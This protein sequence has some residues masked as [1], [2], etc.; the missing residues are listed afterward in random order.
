MH[1][2]RLLGTL[3]ALG[4]IASAA[5][6]GQRTSLAPRQASPYWLGQVQH[7]GLA[8]FNSNPQSYQVF[9]NVKDFGAKGDGV[10][11]DSDAINAAIQAGNRCMKGCDSSTTQPGLIYFPS[12]TYL[13]TK[14]IIAVY[15]S[16]L[17]GDAATLPVIKAAGSFS[18]IAVFDSD[19]Y[20][21]DG[22][23]W[24]TNQ[25]N[26]FRAI[27]NFV[28]D[29]TATQS[30]T[31][32]HWQ[33]A[34]ASSLINIRFEMGNTDSQGI[35][36]DNGSGGFMSDLVFRGGKLGAFL[37]NQ[38]FTTRNF[39]FEGVKTAMVLNWNWG[40][41]FKSLDIKNCG[42]GIDMTAGGAEAQT[43]GSVL[44]LDSKI[45]N[46]PIGI[47]TVHSS[48]S[49][50]ITG[51]TLVIDNLSTNNVPVI[52]ANNDGGAILAGSGGATKVESWGQGRVYSPNG[53]SRVQA[54]LTP[55]PQKPAALLDG[56]G[57]IFERSRPQYTDV[58]AAQIV[59]ARSNGAKGD[60]M[61]DDTA[62]LQAL[63]NNNVGKVIFLDHGVYKLTSTLYIPPNTKIV[64][65]CWATLISEGPFFADSKNPKVVIQVGKP[66]EVGL[67]E[68]SDL[69]LETAGPAGGAIVLQWNMADAP[70]TKGTNGMWDVHI[71]I[72]GSAGT[73]LQSDQCKKNPSADGTQINHNCESAFMLMHIGK[74]GSVY[75]ENNWIWTSDHELDRNDF[76][77]ITIFSG[78]GLWI[79][80]QEGPVWGY[81]T[82]SE[83]NVMYQYQLTNTKN[84]FLGM[85][86]TETPYY[87]S[88]PTVYLPYD[89]NPAFEDP[90]YDCPDKSQGSTCAKSIGLRV[91]DSKDILVYGAGLYS[92][93][94]NYTQ[95]CLKTQTCQDDM[96]SVEGNTQNFFM[97]N[98]NTVGV[99]NM[100]KVNERKLVPQAENQNGFASTI[101]LFAQP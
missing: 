1:L 5:P 53:G 101:A 78:R 57:Y 52:V 98:L 73:K 86:Q 43:V 39:V 30:G 55:R 62:A 32:I 90:V 22:S 19:P 27:R 38:Q 83:H 35:F 42:V 8:A 88:N 24:Y 45:S 82:A 72:G 92:F 63:I 14:P 31:G 68:L 29:L 26:F 28:I 33:V 11:D 70:G 71:R 89:V 23:N 67:V 41:T 13:V 97:Y 66:G 10:T 40:W 17:V 87:Q 48:T 3:C 81:A 12:G 34:Q 96:V 4:Q 75:M 21:S 51:G 9:R 58:P 93:F 18:G 46:T 15:Y 69:V 16:Q 61:T 25:N 60:G 50:P 2:L 80:T 56:N 99:S 65:E 44:V 84:V 54:N 85:I 79:E 77:Q 91:K 94:E 49:Q 95:E 6:I 59:S 37:G 20:E 36:M 47:K 74:T 7:Q 76:S 64:G 100:V